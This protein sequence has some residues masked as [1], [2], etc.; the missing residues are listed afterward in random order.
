[1]TNSVLSSKLPIS[2]EIENPGSFNF[3]TLSPEESLLTP[4]C[5]VGETG[6]SITPYIEVVAS[7]TL[8]YGEILPCSPPLVLS[9]E[10]SQNSEVQSV[11]KPSTDPSSEKLEVLSRGV[12]STMS[13]R[14]FDRDLPEG[15]DPE[16][17][18]LIAGVELMVV[19]SLASLRGDV[20]P[21]LLEQELR[22]LE[23]VRHTVL[24]VFDQTP[25]SFDVDSDK[26]EKEEVPLKWNRKW[27]RGANTLRIGVPD[28]GQEEVW[29]RSEMLK[30]MGSAI[31]ANEIQTERV[32]KRRQEGHLPEEPTSTLLHV[33]SSDTESD[34]FTELWQNKERKLRLRGLNQRKV[35]IVDKEMTRE[36][37]KTEMENQ[38][39]LNGRFFDPDIITEFG[40]SNLFDVI[41]L[42]GWVLLFEP[43]VPYLH[44]PEVREFYYKMELLENGGNRTS[45]KNIKIFLDEETLGI[46]LGVPVR[47]IRSIEGCKP[48]VSSQNRPQSMGTSSV[49]GCQISFSRENISYSLSS[50]TR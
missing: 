42:Q 3:S 2:Q 17:N 36:E 8:P 38:K 1:M 22:S 14:L 21:T 29:T 34:D 6:E 19:Q 30:V 5:G 26:E 20:Q 33:R 27:V 47:G 48:S 35:R 31:A 18:I 40:M 50:S 12:S 32:R 16:L 37:R 23:Q 45:F 10:K 43:P 4:V 13:E 24:S 7:H 28:M 46:I 41:C 44:E 49:Q 39:V 25:R 9:G 15:K 11:I